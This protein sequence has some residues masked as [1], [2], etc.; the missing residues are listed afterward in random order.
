MTKDK[1]LQLR[2]SDY[3]LEQLD[4][5][6]K[7]MGLTK[8]ETIRRSLSCMEENTMDKMFGIDI[9]TIVL[10]FNGAYDVKDFGI[11]DNNY[12]SGKGFWIEL[13]AN[14]KIAI[15]NGFRF[16][17]TEISFDNNNVHIRGGFLNDI[18]NA[19]SML[20]NSSMQLK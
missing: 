6:S 19:L 17:E 1:T 16:R 18:Q 2:V 5:L 9:L 11:I 15:T 7:K 12:L 8:S 20:Y 13:T 4:R 14:F 3:T 10:P